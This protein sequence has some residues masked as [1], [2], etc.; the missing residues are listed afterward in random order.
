MDNP[1]AF[2]DNKFSVT[3]EELNRKKNIIIELAAV[4]NVKIREIRCY[5][6]P[7]VTLFK[8]FPEVVVRGSRIRGLIEDLPFFLGLKGVRCVIREN[9][10]DVEIANDK[11]SVVPLKC[12]LESDAFH[13]S[14]ATLPLAIGLSCEDGAKVID[15]ATAPHLL[16][17]G[18]TK[19]GK[20][21][22]MDTMIASLL[23]SKSP[24][25]VKF[26]FIDP[27]GDEFKEYRG[28]MDQYSAVQ[29]GPD[30]MLEEA[31][32]RLVSLLAEMEARYDSLLKESA[33]SIE[34][35]NGLAEQVLPHI[36]CFVDEFSD[37]TME[38]GLSPDARRRARRIQKAIL[39]LAARGRA[40]GIH[41]ILATQRPSKDV[42]TNLIKANFPTRIAFRTTCMEDS[43]T[44]LDMPGAEKLTGDGDMILSSGGK[45]ERL[46]CAYVSK[47][48][49][50]SIVRFHS[51]Q[52]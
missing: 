17:A 23:F 52:N 49:I 26:V 43:L 3:E 31:D 15:L 5:V 51:E 28:L 8:V 42:I 41:L 40:A 13:E 37:L 30:G 44:I 11:R 36:V 35:Y 29:P 33:T 38:F 19:Q 47:D 21:V 4:R 6:G 20:S 45:S 12:L 25:E 32:Y 22:C 18:A 14:K 9:C 48:E 1:S 2:P 39:L 46:Q 7:S 16:L 34:E 24:S 27:K 10:I 50:R